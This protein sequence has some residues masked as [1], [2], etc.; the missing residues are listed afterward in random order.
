MNL[1][2]TSLHA[3]ESRLEGKGDKQWES[4]MIITKRSVCETKAENESRRAGSMNQSGTDC[5]PKESGAE[6]K[7]LQ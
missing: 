4:S 6:E 2:V 5:Q 1:F 3:R 7:A